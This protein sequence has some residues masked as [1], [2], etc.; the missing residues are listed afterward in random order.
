MELLL[1]IA[2]V[3][4]AVNALAFSAFWVDKRRAVQNEWR[5]SESTLLGLAFFGG[6]V[7]AKLA[8]RRFRHKTRK[9]PFAAHLNAVPVLWAILAFLAVAVPHIPQEWF[10]AD[11]AET[12]E[13]RRISKS[14][15]QI[16][17]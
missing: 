1:L 15:P 2:L 3:L 12:P 16:R 13:P 4:F 5:I 17:F 7:G 9:Q 8:Q 6:W 10:D 11:T 14:L